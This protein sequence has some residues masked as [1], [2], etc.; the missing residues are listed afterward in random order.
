MMTAY[1][2]VSRAEPDFYKPLFLNVFLIFPLIL[3]VAGC[4]S[5][6]PAP[7]VPEDFSLKGKVAVRDGEAQFSANILWQQRGNGFEIDLWGPLGQGRVQLVKQGE[8][9]ILK[10]GRGEVLTEGDAESVMSRHLGW[11]LPIDVLPA[12]IQGRPLAAVGSEDL[13]YGEDGELLAFRQLDWQ[14]R[15]DRYRQL[16]G[17]GGIRNLPGRVTAEKQAARVR[18]VITE[19]R[20]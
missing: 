3:L 10:D 2:N 9:V 16:Q 8:Q 6:P 13:T 1:S 12:W 17:V 5:M 18:L 7:T 14:V 20:I 4:V 19:W 11:S 15:L